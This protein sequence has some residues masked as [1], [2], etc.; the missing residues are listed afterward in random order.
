MQRYPGDHDWPKALQYYRAAAELCAG[1]ALIWIGVVGLLAA[2]VR[3]RWWALA[4]LA[5][6]PA[7]FVLSMYSRVRRSTC[8]ICGRTL[9]TTRATGWRRCRCWHSAA[10]RIVSLIPERWRD[11]RSALL[12]ALRS[13]SVAHAH[14]GAESWITGKRVE[15]NSVARRAWT[16]EA[17]R[18]LKENYHQGDGIFFSFGDL[19]ASSRSRHPVRE[20]SARRQQSAIGRSV[21]RPDL[22][23]WEEWALAFRAI[24]LHCAI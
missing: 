19:T 2:I 21:A 6:P 11:R 24:T 8:R 9:T 18:F 7:F 20:S 14:P 16:A 4:I 17:A 12:L 23:L 5:V 3:R 15:V 1:P 10:R 22:F 13:C